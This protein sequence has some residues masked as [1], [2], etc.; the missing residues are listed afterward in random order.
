M[1]IYDPDPAINERIQRAVRYGQT[2]WAEIWLSLIA[3]VS[4]QAPLAGAI[5]ASFLAACSLGGIRVALAPPDS[6]S[7]AAS[8]AQ[9]GAGDGEFKALAQGLKTATD[10][11]KRFAEKAESEIKSL[12]KM[13]EETK[14]GADKA[15]TE[16]NGKISEFDAR[17]ADVEQKAARRGGHAVEAK[18]L[19]QH[20][21]DSGRA[22]SMLAD[23]SAHKGS[24]RVTIESK[25]ITS[26]P[27]RGG[28]ATTCRRRRRSASPM[29][30]P[31]SSRGPARRSI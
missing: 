10:E 20:F 24:A 18:S 1:L 5:P 27:E 13:T 23:G 16:M 26:A 15:I 4:F 29:C 11:V 8:G 14:A 17:L 7:A 2:R 22:K 6:G 12:G 25:N 19:G 28:I 3:G 31:H 30:Q 9:G 21:I